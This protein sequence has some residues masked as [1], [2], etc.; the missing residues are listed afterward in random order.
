M[1]RWTSTLYKFL[2]Q[3]PPRRGL[4][5]EAALSLILARLALRILPFRHLKPFF[6]R[7][8]KGPQ[9]NGRQRERL[10]KEVAWAIDRTA[11]ILPGETVCF[12][13]G[14]AAQAMLRRRGVGVSLYYGVTIP[15]DRG[16]IAHVWVQDGMQGVVGHCDTAI[17]H[18]LARYPEPQKQSIDQQTDN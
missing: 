13:R 10:R 5:L 8:V 9:M 11:K 16:P 14:I 18:V 12:P 2:H 4:L 1:R 7:P 17:Y 3:T 15:S 6:N